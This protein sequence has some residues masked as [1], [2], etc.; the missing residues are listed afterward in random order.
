MKGND[1]MDIVHKV[2][3]TIIE[4]QLFEKN[5][6]VIVAVSG[7]ADSVALLHILHH[8]S[9]T[10][11]WRLIVAHVNHQFRGDESDEE[12]ESVRRLAKTFEM[13]CEIGNI[14][15]PEYIQR[16]SLNTQAAAREKRYQFLFQIAKQFNA[17]KLA[18]GHHADDQAETLLMRLVRGSSPS[19]LSG[20]PIRRMEQKVELVRPLLR[21]YKSELLEFCNE[22]SIHFC[23]DSSNKER[24]YIRNQVRLDM[25]PFLQ[26]WNRQ[27][28]ESLNRLSSMMKDEDDFM[29]SETKRRFEQ[30][31][32]ATPK[33][34][35]FSRESYLTLPV[36]LQRRLIT[37]I[38]KY[39]S[40]KAET[41][42]YT[43]VELIRSALIQTNTP[44]M[45]LHLNE[46]ISFIREY[47]Q[48][49]MGQGKLEPHNDYAYITDT[50]P[51]HQTISEA[52]MEIFMD[53]KT[54]EDIFPVKNKD[55]NQMHLDLDQ[56]A[57]PIMIRN[58]RQGDR[59]NIVGLKGTKKVKDIFIDEKVP[60]SQ[61]ERIPIIVDADG[62][63]LWIPG[64]RK[65]EQSAVTGHTVR[66]LHMMYKHFI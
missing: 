20:M 16:H 61:R 54:G 24:K 42:D 26:R 15:V 36:A 30:I 60:P 47:D 25:M 7:G 53:V 46:H 52:G 34:C 3:Q 44:S 28:P 6:T 8:L 10:W 58:R 13:P 40:P 56:I 4:Q 51:F 14:N 11:N 19:G 2:E 17:Q 21:I 33:D 29:E 50:F 22:R 55:L 38:L 64:I 5:D 27:L 66:I 49:H 1:N 31:I 32:N 62:Q 18:L 35:F 39:L 57:L 37:L 63:L 41:Y 12:A 23:E 48:I 9:V 59:I 43:K 45:V 65:S